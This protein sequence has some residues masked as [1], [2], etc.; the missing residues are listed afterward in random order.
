MAKKPAKFQL[1]VLS[2]YQRKH[3]SPFQHSFLLVHGS[4]GV[5]IPLGSQSTYWFSDPF[6]LLA[7]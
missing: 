7:F 1:F 5:K 6:I 4:Q 2:L 3:S